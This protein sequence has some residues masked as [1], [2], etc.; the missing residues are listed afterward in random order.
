VRLYLRLQG[1]QLRIKRLPLQLD[2]SRA[3]S[4]ALGF[5]LRDPVLVTQIAIPQR[6]HDD[7]NRHKPDH[8]PGCTVDDAGDKVEDA[9][10]KTGDAIEDAADEVEDAVDDK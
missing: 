10:D 6:R 4:S 2:N 1:P 5:G 3:L 7:R 8:D 9:A